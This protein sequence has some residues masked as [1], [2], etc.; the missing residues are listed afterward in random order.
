VDTESELDKPDFDAESYVLSLLAREGLESVLKVEAGL[1][2]EV[3]GLDG[4]K[5]ALVYD[6]YSKLIAA[7]ETIRSMRE[8]MDPMTPT[9][10]TLK[11]AIGHI[12]ETAAT[13]S[14]ELR[15]QHG[16]SGGLE[17]QEVKSKQEQQKSVRWVL[18]APERLRRTI[19]DGHKSEAD[20]DWEEVSKLLNKWQN[21]KGVDAVRQACLEAMQRSAEG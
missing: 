3:R 8:K 7:T 18:D 20:A 5:K 2:G 19:A 14:G 17:R 11:P 6:N 16:A 21:V 9:T 13:L 15:K 1:V 4:E 10:S 12:A